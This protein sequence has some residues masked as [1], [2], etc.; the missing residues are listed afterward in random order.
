MQTHS[1]AAELFHEDGRMD[2][3]IIVT[4]PSVAK[5]PKKIIMCLSSTN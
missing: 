3:T 5:A 1:V 4:F 2:M